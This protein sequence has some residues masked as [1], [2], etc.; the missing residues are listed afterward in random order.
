[1]TASDHVLAITLRKSLHAG[2]HPHMRHYPRFT[3]VT[4]DGD[5]PFRLET[6]LPAA[7]LGPVLFK[8]LRR[9]AA[10]W[11]AVAMGPL[12]PIP[13]HRLTLEEF[14]SP[15]QSWG[16]PRYELINAENPVRTSGV[17]REA[18]MARRLPFFAL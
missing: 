14:R 10:I 9:L 6:A 2:G 13:S 17:S 18:D 7:V 5:D 3:I 1:M 16:P 4:L 15:E 8:A 11:A 12:D